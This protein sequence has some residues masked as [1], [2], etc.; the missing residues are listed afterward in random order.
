MAEARRR[1]KLFSRFFLHRRGRP[2]MVDLLYESSSCTHGLA[3][4][5]PNRLSFLR[6]HWAS[7]GQT[8]EPSGLIMASNTD[9]PLPVRVFS[10]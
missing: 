6:E 3:R 8:V 5:A 2:Q 4:R 9:S 1:A 10:R 7:A